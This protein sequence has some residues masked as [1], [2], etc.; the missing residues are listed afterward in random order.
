MHLKALC[1]VHQF[2]IERVFAGDF[3]EKVSKFYWGQRVPL[4]LTGDSMGPMQSLLGTPL[5]DAGLSKGKEPQVV[6][7]KGSPSYMI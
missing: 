2:Q 1:I 6:N 4:K 3:M 7:E 5:S